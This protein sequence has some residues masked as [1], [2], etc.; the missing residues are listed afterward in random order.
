MHFEPFQITQA[1]KDWLEY[2]DYVASMIACTFGLSLQELGVRTVEGS[3]T[4][5]VYL[6]AEAKPIE[7]QEK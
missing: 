1:D 7:T 5:P 2:Q 3:I 4:V 6:I